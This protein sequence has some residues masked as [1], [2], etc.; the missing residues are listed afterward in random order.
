ME[1]ARMGSPEGKNGLIHFGPFELD[2]HEQ[3]LRKRGAVLK[4]Q[5]KQFV[6]LHLLAERPGE[7][8]SRQEIQQRVWGDGTHVDF[9]RGINF[10][11][12]QIRAALGDDADRPRY[13]ETIPRRGY[14]F[15]ANVDGN[16]KAEPDISASLIPGTPPP[17]R[18]NGYDKLQTPPPSG[19]TTRGKILA[20]GLALLA[21]AIAL[22]VLRPWNSGARSEQANTA[23]R[24]VRTFPLMTFEGE[25]FGVALSP[26]AS[27]IA[28]T[29][30]G[31]DFAKWNI[32]VQ[33]I[34]GDRPLQITHTQEGMI[35]WVDWSPDGRLLVF[36]RCGDDNHGSLYTIPALGGQEH[37]V[38]DVAC[39]LGAV[40]AVW[41]PD[42]QSLLFSDACKDAD[43][44][45]IV[46]LPLATGKKRCLA[47]PDSNSIGLYNPMVSP[48]GRNVAFVRDTTARV[49]DL[50]TVPIGGG[51]PRQLTFE[52]R[53]LGQFV[54]AADGKSI[55]FTS[56]REG[57][58]GR[59]I[60]RV[61]IKGGRIEP[62]NDPLFAK[63][64]PGQIPLSALSRDRRRIVY[65]DYREDNSVTWRARLA[66]AGG[67]VIA[68]EKV[69]QSSVKSGEPRLSSDGTHIAYMSALS[70]AENIWT[71]DAGGHNTLQLTSFSGELLGTPG[72]SPDGKWLVFDRRPSDHAQIY[73]IDAEGRN[74]H[75][76]TEGK[77]ENDVPIWSRNGKAVYFTSD[78]TGRYELWKQDIASAVSTQITQHGGFSGVESYDGRYLYYTKHYCSGIWRMPIDGGEEE[79]IIN[80]PEPWYSRYWDISESGVYFYDVAASPRPAIKY[81]DFKTRQTTTILEPQG[82][83]MEWS[84][85]ISVSRDG[86][87]LVYGMRHS[88][89]TLMVTEQIR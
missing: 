33:R 8:V 35:A 56:D 69:L 9:D 36:G 73:M 86:R 25:F 72:W 54:W 51:T 2:A 57:V 31:P 83:A 40:E 46:A 50:F 75:A 79:R 16:G 38:T 44:L 55:I 34:G 77:H 67:K 26:D 89:S 71:S 15:I 11:I 47:A 12:N 23:S 20:G 48:D 85:G 37:K 4:L 24:P 6:V 76:L 10:C 17:T 18:D 68:H 59:K 49:S 61:S 43:A 30:N 58:G 13:I 45:G 53:R 3:Q 1:G 22:A 42:G 84:Q 88:T 52:G 7:I 5:P 21:I 82:Q 74:M 39:D 70:G 64:H 63:I 41:A 32:Y 65:V 81:Y 60:W 78:R 80:S 66:T 28:F 19:F 27:Q 62:E 29:W 14:R 87:T